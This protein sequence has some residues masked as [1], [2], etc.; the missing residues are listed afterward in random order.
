[1]TFYFV[2][3][4]DNFVCV[5]LSPSRLYSFKTKTL[6]LESI[7]LCKKQ[8]KDKNARWWVSG[9]GVEL[10]QIRLV[11]LI[12]FVAHIMKFAAGLLP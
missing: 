3:F 4:F 2:L 5:V 8:T 9:S 6:R 11:V 12:T 10:L 7:D 1:M